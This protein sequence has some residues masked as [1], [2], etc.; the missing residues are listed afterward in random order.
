MLGAKKGKQVRISPVTIHP[1]L[2]EMPAYMHERHK[3]GT[4]AV[5]I[6]YVNKT[7][8]FVTSYSS[9]QVKCLMI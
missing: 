7:P 5:D 6:M 9:V 8:F 3:I 4:V 2:S 1:N